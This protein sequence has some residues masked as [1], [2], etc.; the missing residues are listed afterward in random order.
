MTDFSMMQ[1]RTRVLGWWGR[2]IAEV[3]ASA[4][5]STNRHEPRPPGAKTLALLVPPEQR[6]RVEAAQRRW[7][8]GSFARTGQTAIMV[9]LAV[10]EMTGQQPDPR[11]LDVLNAIRVWVR[12]GHPRQGPEFIALTRNSER[13]HDHQEDTADDRDERRDE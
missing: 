2:R 8:L 1:Y 3:K 7:H 11:T 12:A 10:M 6:E 4:S 5:W 9:G 13:W